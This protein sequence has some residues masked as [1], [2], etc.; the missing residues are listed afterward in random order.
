ML[1][2]AFLILTPLLFVGILAVLI[3]A[4]MEEM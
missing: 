2:W 4:Y 1:L 3:L